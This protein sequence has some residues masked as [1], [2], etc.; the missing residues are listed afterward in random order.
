MPSEACE[1]YAVCGVVDAAMTVQK[2]SRDSK[3]SKVFWA[4]VAFWVLKLTT[5]Y[6]SKLAEVCRSS[7]K[8]GCR[9]SACPSRRQPR[10]L[11]SHHDH[12]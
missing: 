2:W 6:S 5:M 10:H 4:F 12:G 8:A 9:H 7:L 11:D 1:A 3:V